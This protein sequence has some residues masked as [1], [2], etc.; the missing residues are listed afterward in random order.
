M[1][2]DLQLIAQAGMPWADMAMLITNRWMIGSLGEALGELDI[3]YEVITP[4]SARTMD[5]GTNR[6]KV[7]TIHAAKGLEFRVVCIL[8]LENLKDQRELDLEPVESSK[9]IRS[10]RLGLVGA[11]RA[12][13]LLLI[14]YRKD[15]IFLDRLRNSGAPFRAWT[16]PD[17]YGS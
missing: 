4:A 10:A 11:T 3:P 8:G 15:N 12:R 5:L 16:W 6:V 13:D 14:T 1:A 2:H 17:D 9:R 7:L